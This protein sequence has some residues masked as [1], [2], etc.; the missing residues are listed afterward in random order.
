MALVILVTLD[1]LQTDLL[2][3]PEPVLALVSLQT[4]LLVAA[5][6]LWLKTLRGI[7]EAVRNQCLHRNHEVLV[8]VVR[9]LNALTASL[10]VERQEHNAS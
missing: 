9:L 3:I 10:F 7:V 8:R 1:S 4:R 6:L 5:P 2:V